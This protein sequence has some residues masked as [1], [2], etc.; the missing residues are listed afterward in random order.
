MLRKIRQANIF[1]AG[2]FSN[3]LH[4]TIEFSHDLEVPV[5]EITKGLFSVTASVNASDSA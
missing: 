5:G 2:Q 4:R 3:D 1:T